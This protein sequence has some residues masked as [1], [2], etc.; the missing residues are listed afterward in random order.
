[1]L[2]LRLALVIPWVAALYGSLCLHDLNLHLATHGI[3]G[4][5]GC[6]PPTEALLGMHAFWLV[7]LVPVGVVAGKWLPVTLVRPMGILFLGLGCIGAV[8]YVGWDAWSFCQ[9]SQSTAFVVQR[10]LFTVAT[11]VDIPFVQVAV[12][13]GA[14]IWFARRPI[15]SPFMDRPL[16][17]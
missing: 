11:T 8:G 4:P 6:G 1:M 10:A 3:C 7:L 12:A 9:A 16:Q 5:W 2:A 13:G 17:D 14:V 15:E